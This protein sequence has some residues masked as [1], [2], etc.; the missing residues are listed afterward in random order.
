MANTSKLRN[1]ALNLVKVL[2][3][4]E[5]VTRIRSRLYQNYKQAHATLEKK[6]MDEK[7][8]RIMAINLQR[9]KKVLDIVRNS[10][11]SV[12]SILRKAES[13]I[14]H[15]EFRRDLIPLAESMMEQIREV[16]K[17]AI[18]RIKKVEKRLAMEAKLEKS[19]YD[20]NIVKQ[21]VLK[22]DN[23][24]KEIDQQVIS[25][26]KGEVGVLNKRFIDYL[27]KAKL[28]AE[29]AVVG[30]LLTPILIFNNERYVE[31]FAEKMTLTIAHQP[32]EALIPA[33]VLISFAAVSCVV[34]RIVSADRKEAGLSFKY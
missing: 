16:M 2:R 18:K 4:I 3:K 8:R 15:T 20:P 23:E 19:N 1:D 9:E 10:A 7:A 5:Q 28:R 33:I 34:G 30:A 6:P 29:F 25:F 12:R 26:L 27:N 14:K 21:F 13:A 31:K 11:N 32:D 24:R 17:F 22:F